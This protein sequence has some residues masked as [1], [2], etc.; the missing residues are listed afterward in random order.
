M[1]SRSLSCEATFLE[2]VGRYRSIKPLTRAKVSWPVFSPYK[3]IRSASRSSRVDISPVPDQGT[4]DFLTLVMPLCFGAVTA[5]LH[6]APATAAVPAGIE[7]GKPASILIG[8][9]THPVKLGRGQQIGS[10]AGN[11]SEHPSQIIRIQYPTPSQT[12]PERAS[13]SS[14]QQRGRFLHS[15]Y[16]GRHRSAGFPFTCAVRIR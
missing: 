13:I 3:K 10:R 15:I 2:I 8:A 1:A 5:I 9:D 4:I 11:R 16:R 12:H 14:F 6:A 7:E